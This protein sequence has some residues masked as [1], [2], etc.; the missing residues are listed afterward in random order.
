PGASSRPAAKNSRA[1][2]GSF[3]LAFSAALRL[4]SQWILSGFR[5]VFAAL[6]AG[7]PGP[8]FACD[9]MTPLLGQ[10]AGQP[11][12][13]FLSLVLETLD[14]VRQVAAVARFDQLDSDVPVAHHRG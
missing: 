1:S 6:L 5:D 9:V 14:E 12:F 2:S 8:P 11:P 10:H 7:E 3:S 13:R 4:P